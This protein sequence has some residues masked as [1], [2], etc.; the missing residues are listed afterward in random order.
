MSKT[1]K[2]CQTHIE[3]F[4]YTKKEQ[5]NL[6]RMLSK[7]VFYSRAY[8]TYQPFIFHI[9]KDV[10]YIPRGISPNYIGKIFNANPIYDEGPDP[11][12]HIASAEM[13][14][15][16]RN[17]IQEEAIRFFLCEGE[18]S[19]NKNFTQFALNLDTGDGKTYTC[20]HSLLKIGL[21]TI[22]ITHQEKIK[23][24]WLNTFNDMSSVNL[25]RIC[26]ISGSEIIQEILEL[27]KTPEYDFYLVNHQTLSGYGRKHGWETIKEFFEKIKVGVKVVDEAHLFFENTLMIDFFSNTYKTFYLTATF[28]RS[29]AQ[30][31]YLFKKAFLSV[32]RFG[33]ETFN[34]EEKRKHV[35]F[36]IVYFKSTPEHG[37]IPKVT[38]GHGF[39]SYLYIDYELS[40][41]S[42]GVLL[43][44][45]RRL[46]DQTKQLEGRRLILSPKTDSAEYFKEQIMDRF[47]YDVGT[48]H[49]K[50]GIEVNREN[51]KKEFISSTSKSFGVG[52]DLK[53][54]RMMIN[55]EPIGSAVLADQ[56]RGRLRE[57]SPD[58]DT[59]LFYPIDMIF[60][61]T[62]RMLKKIIPV[63]KRKCKEIII[64]NMNDM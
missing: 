26:N 57:Y 25:K 47:P 14:Y 19:N 43:R 8:Y 21:R 58:K 54:L 33:E 64:M 24:Q 49:S 22:I 18:F 3:V 48:I 30:E 7:K 16:P 59:F 37:I 55:T 63:M 29:D 39:S 34:Y 61:D 4:P 38:T 17:D 28:N 15:E 6:E 12:Y 52:V 41:R 9:E 40:E 20:V 5:P 27:N 50:N 32:V 45:V 11:Y 13:L 10:L 51:M 1:I 36:V 35:V 46:I 62:S 2:I 56:I 23:T 31:V 44:V 42:G 53:G 60:K